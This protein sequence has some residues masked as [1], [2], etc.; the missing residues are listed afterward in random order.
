M[1]IG[2][3]VKLP[4]TGRPVGDVVKSP[5]TRDTDVALVVVQLSTDGLPCADIN[6][7]LAV[8]DRICVEPTFTVTLAWI[9]PVALVADK[10]YVVV[11]CG[12]TVTQALACRL[13]PIPLLMLMLV[14][15]FTC[16]QSCELCPALMVCGLA[17]KTTTCGTDAGI[18]WML[19]TAVTIMPLALA[20]VRV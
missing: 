9:W 2:V 17:E 4:L 11:V 12:L 18:T 5:P 3:T 16:Q 6:S 8:N 15:P 7:G 14:A 19:I 20:A 1:S 13:L 10:T